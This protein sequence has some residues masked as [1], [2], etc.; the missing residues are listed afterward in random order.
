[1][2]TNQGPCHDCA[3]LILPAPINSMEYGRFEII[4]EARSEIVGGRKLVVNGA[5]HAIDDGCLP[6]RL[7]VDS[8]IYRRLGHIGW[9][10]QCVRRGESAGARWVRITGTWRLEIVASHYNVKGQF[11]VF[12]Q[13]HELSRQ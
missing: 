12:N 5:R 6:R 13:F 2:G 7:Y 10:K 4:V 3:G 1:M 8:L 9:R 11:S